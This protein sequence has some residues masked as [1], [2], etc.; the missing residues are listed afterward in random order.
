MKVDVNELVKELSKPDG[1]EQYKARVKLRNETARVGGRGQENERTELAAALA[2]VVADGQPKERRR[3]YDRP[4]ANTFMRCELLRYLCEIAG[5]AEVPVLMKAVDDFE[6]RDFIRRV[7]ESIPGDEATAALVKM[8]VEEEGNEFRVGAINALG[9]RKSPAAMEALKTCAA[10]PDP[11]IR[12]AAADALAA[13]GDPTA[14]SVIGQSF[15]PNRGWAPHANAARTRLRLAGNVAK[16]GN[17]A[18]A[19]QINQ[20]VLAMQP[21]PYQVKAATNGLQGQTPP[22]R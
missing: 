2:K 5:P 15:D 16:S 21:Q 17:K 7:V 6:V 11:R 19:D 1:P 3:I 9:N 12:L 18:A 8:A 20:G 13:M 14:D 10:D 4:F 22:R